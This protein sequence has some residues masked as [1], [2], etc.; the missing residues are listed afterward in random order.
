[1]T[2]IHEKYAIPPELEAE[3]EAL[4][5]PTASTYLD[6]LRCA[7]IEVMVMARRHATDRRLRDQIDAILVEHVVPRIRAVVRRH[8]GVPSEEVDEAEGEAMVLFWEGIQRESFFEVRFNLAMKYLA[9]RAGRN[10]RGGKQGEHERSAVRTGSMGDEDPDAHN[11]PIDIAD[12]V[13]AYSQ[14][15][16]R[17]L[18]QI[19]LASLPDEQASALSLHYLMGLPIYSNESAV[20]TVACELGCGER[21]AR[22]LIADGKAAL[23]R[24]IGQEDIDE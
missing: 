13:D 12:D 24:L 18:V 23:R 8:S 17:H 21:K 14:M 9:K 11:A 7:S 5:A 19:G 3:L 22:K 16:N 10:I 4:P 6:R 1:M 2:M 20:P 15:E